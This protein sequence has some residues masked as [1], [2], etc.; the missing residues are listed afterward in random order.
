MFLCII[1]KWID[2]RL[3]ECSL[4]FNLSNQFH[5]WVFIRR[6]SL[7]QKNVAPKCVRLCLRRGLTVWDTTKQTS[8]CLFQQEAWP[9]WGFATKNVQVSRVCVFQQ[10]NVT[11]A[12]C[13]RSKTACARVH[14]GGLWCDCTV[15]KKTE[16]TKKTARH[17]CPPAVFG[18]RCRAM[19]GPPRCA[20]LCVCGA[21]QWSVSVVCVSGVCVCRGWVLTL[22]CVAGREASGQGQCGLK[23][24]LE[25]QQVVGCLGAAGRRTGTGERSVFFPFKTGKTPQQ[26]LPPA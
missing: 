16:L 8:C 15:N 9:W 10:K 26:W 24:G 18:E 11:T 14:D 6:S 4:I 20:L 17:I 21:C 23:G 13:V 5:W 3:W 19:G 7:H 12:S 2:W 22:P 1:K 25:V